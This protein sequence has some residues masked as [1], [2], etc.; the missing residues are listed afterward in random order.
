MADLFLGID[1]GSSVLKAA[2]FDGAGRHLAIASRRTPLDRPRPGWVEADPEACLTALDAVIA[3]VAQACGRPDA[4]AAIGVSGAMVGAWLVDAD[5]HAIRPGIN[6]EDSRSQSLLD[7][8]SADR[9]SLMS[10]IF[11]ISGSVLQQGCTLPLLAWFKRNAPEALAR[12]AHALTYKDFLR[13]HLT[14]TFTAD[15]SEA[16]VLPGDARTQGRSAELMRLFG[17][18]DLEALLPEPLTSQGVAGH[19]TEAA[20]LRTGLTAGIPVVAGAGDVIANVIGA[21]GLRAG[22]ATAILGTTCMVGVSHDEPVFAPPDL[23]LLFSL[24]ER[25]WYR[26]MVNVAGTLNLDWALNLM[27]PDLAGDPERFAK[28][29]A[30]AEAVPPGANGVTYLPYLSE[31]GIIAP[32]ADPHA[33]AQFCGLHAGHGR[34]DM[35]RAVF[36][37]VAFAFA[38]LVDLLSIAPATP[39]TLTGGGSRSALWCRMIA[40]VTGRSVIVPGETEFGAR[41]AALLAATALGRFDSVTAASRA[42]AGSVNARHDPAP[43]AGEAWREPRARFAQARDRLLGLG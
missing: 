1:A 24:P 9:P 34:A 37:G 25:H 11:A 19:L 3:E 15:R 26:A 13:H 21:G 6:W 29:T 12:A 31:S 10:D 22:A 2:V 43:G 5:G 20:A 38:D 41:G 42:V 40:D 23:G 16:A 14:G 7:Q 39:I 4:I 30:M 28:V 35:I 8:L 36:E 33:R 32:V 27:A 17:I 18:A